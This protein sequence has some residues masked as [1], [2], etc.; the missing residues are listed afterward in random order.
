MV[1]WALGLAM[2]ATAVSIV[3]SIRNP[4]I[5]FWQAVRIAFF[6]RSFSGCHA[7]AWLAGRPYLPK[8]D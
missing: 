6:F 2:D 3:Q 1:F 5:A 4:G 8:R 7:F